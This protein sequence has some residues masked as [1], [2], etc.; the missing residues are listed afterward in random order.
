MAHMGLLATW[1]AW[2]P[3][4]QAEELIQLMQSETS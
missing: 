1:A 4:G 3:P 2:L